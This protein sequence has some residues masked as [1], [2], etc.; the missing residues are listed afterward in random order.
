VAIVGELPPDAERAGHDLTYVAQLG[1]VEPPAMPRTLLADLAGAERAVSATLA[2]LLKRARGGGISRAYVSLR[3]S[4]RLFG[5]PYAHGLTSEGGPLGGGVAGYGV[6]RASDGW[7]A[8]A[9]LEPHFMARM[10]EKL[11]VPPGDAGGLAARFAE[12]SVADWQAWAGEHDLP[13]I[14]VAG[15]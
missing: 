14:G 11:D 9:A 7:V 4:A 3:E 5:L 10:S 2:L 12:K 1:L 13:V 15:T 6:Y 8:V